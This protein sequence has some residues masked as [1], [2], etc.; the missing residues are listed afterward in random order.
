MNLLTLF[1]NFL[2]L[3]AGGDWD[4][5]FNYV[6]G[7]VM[8]VVTGIALMCLA[9]LGGKMAIIGWKYLTSGG[10]QQ[11]KAECKED[12]RALVLGLTLSASTSAITVIAIKLFRG[13]FGF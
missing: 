9:F 8:W 12:A 13:K 1:N 11:I 5:S 3:V 7:I 4:E 2:F 6:F 10:D